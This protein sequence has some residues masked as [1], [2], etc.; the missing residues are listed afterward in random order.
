M[1][2]EIEKNNIKE[3]TELADNGDSDAALK[4][5]EYYYN[6][7]EDGDYDIAIEWYKKSAEQG[8]SQ[9]QVKLGVFYS[10][11]FG[12]PENYEKTLELY[13]KAAN[14]GNTDALTRIADCYYNGEILGR[15]K[16]KAFKYYM[17]AAELDDAYGQYMI[18]KYYSTQ[19]Y[20]KKINKKL[21]VAWYKKSAEQGYADA[22][23]ELGGLYKLGNGVEKDEKKALDLLVKA[24]KQGQESA[25]FDVGSWYIDADQVY[26]E[27]HPVPD[28]LTALKCF[29]KMNEYRRSE[30]VIE[31]LN[32]YLE[33]PI[34]D[35]REDSNKIFEFIKD[36]ADEGHSYA[37][38]LLGDCYFYGFGVEQDYLKAIS[39][40]NEASKDFNMQA[41]NGIAYCYFY[42]L[43]VKQ[44][45]E[46]AAE[47][48]NS[49]AIYFNCPAKIICNY[50]YCCYMGKGT[51]RNYNNS[52][53][54][55]R[56]ALRVRPSKVDPIVLYFCGLSSYYGY[57]FNIDFEAAFK[58][59]ERA[60]KSGLYD[61]KLALIACYKK[62]IGVEKNLE[63]A[64]ELEANLDKNGKR[65]SETKMYFRR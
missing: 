9:A 14:D 18:G 55:F 23:Y 35:K 60:S 65:L 16:D 20:K 42:G 47:L 51:P 28:F 11:G 17:K 54:F 6:R 31:A 24:A 36:L 26:K 34:N 4:L 40:Y 22:Q 44:D 3:L 53:E 15:D 37:K 19:D 25:L 64:Q 38:R 43:G 29:I 8:N 45:Y 10:E 39:L 50:A 27:K 59:F 33:L 7:E 49:V 58:Y 61:A 56:S 21:M 63:K 2:N 30:T 5:A 52:G 62:G 48:L 46:K 32:N 41:I 57:G 1:D 12:V 13:F